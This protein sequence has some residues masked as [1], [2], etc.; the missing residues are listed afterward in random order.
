[1]TLSSKIMHHGF[2]DRFEKSLTSTQPTIWYGDK[3]KVFASTMFPISFSNP[4]KSFS[5]FRSPVNTFCLNWVHLARVEASSTTLETIASLL[6]PLVIRSTS[7][8]AAF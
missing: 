2:S 1:M 4:K 8:C 6:K 3:Q 7:S 5:R